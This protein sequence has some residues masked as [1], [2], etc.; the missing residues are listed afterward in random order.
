MKGDWNGS[1]CHTNFSTKNMREGNEVKTGL[2]FIEEAIEK[3]SHKHQEHMAVYGSG[4]EQRMTGEHETASF[5]TFSH[6]V[7]N[8]GAS[9]RIG[10][11]N[12]KNGK[13]YFEDR[14][15]SSN[16]DPYQVTSKMVETVC[17]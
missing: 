13:G 4:N 1:G 2:E 5:D 8:R 6:G 16:C 3:L 11:E 10:N 9:V 17:L 12:K 14:R 15:P 7:A